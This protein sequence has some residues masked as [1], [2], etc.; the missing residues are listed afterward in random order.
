VMTRSKE[1]LIRYSIYVV[2][3][4]LFAALVSFF[5]F[6]TNISLFFND[7]SLMSFRKL[8]RELTD[9]GLSEN[10]FALSIGLFIIF[11]WLVVQYRNHPKVH[12]HNLFV[13]LRKW[14]LNFFVSLIFSGII[15][16]IFKI[17]VGR[18]RP[19]VSDTFDNHVFK[20]FQLNSHYQ[21]FPSGH[22]QVLFCAATMFAILWPRATWFIYVVAFLLSL[23]RV[24]VH[25]H[26]LSDVIV[27]MAVGHLGT[28][29]CLWL[30]EKRYP[31]TF[32]L[33]KSARA[34]GLTVTG[35]AQLD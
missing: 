4:S 15:L 21:S 20:F 17:S 23:T 1:Q 6:D 2:C 22:S 11:H 35:K 18:Q 25:A 31:K 29:W 27:G 32:S 13:W 12:L 3:A 26:F 28:L 19:H 33:D 5:T 30:L 8:A 24:V 10:F 9:V 7:E 14:A 16:F 34:Q